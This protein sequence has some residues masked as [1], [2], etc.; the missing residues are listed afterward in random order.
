M[1]SSISST[2][3][4]ALAA[5]D[6]HPGVFVEGAANLVTNLGRIRRRERKIVSAYRKCYGRLRK[7]KRL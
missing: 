4:G 5:T 2:S 3:Q 6:R 1:K 7:K